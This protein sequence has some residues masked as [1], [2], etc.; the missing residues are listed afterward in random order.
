MSPDVPPTPNPSP[1][2]GLLWRC[3]KTLPAHLRQVF[4]ERQQEGLRQS[5]LSKALAQGHA[6][7]QV[8]DLAHRDHLATLTSFSFNHE[9]MPGGGQIEAVVAL[10]FVPD[11]KRQ[12]RPLCVMATVIALTC[13]STKIKRLGTRL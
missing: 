2:P 11:W 7:P 3:Q 12:R 8:P 4:G 10:W 6:R 1:V 5:L 13:D 9:G